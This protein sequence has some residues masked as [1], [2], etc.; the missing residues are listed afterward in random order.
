MT[1]RPPIIFEPGRDLWAQ[2]PHESSRQYERFLRFRDMG[3]MRSLTDLNKVLTDLGDKL[4]YGTLRTQSFLYRWS[5]RAQAWDRHQDEVDRDRVIQA[6]RDLIDR[7]LKIANALLTKAINALKTT[8]S[9]DLDPSDIVR[10]IKLASDIEIRALGEPTKTIAVTGPAGGPIQTEDLSA[11]TPEER[12][13]RMR[14]LASEFAARA[15]LGQ[16][17]TEDD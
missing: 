12:A 7:H 4:T 1:N 3:R 2:Q 8:K 16:T 10:W 5:E 13:V 6:R 15:G 17:D 14:E 11:L 9:E